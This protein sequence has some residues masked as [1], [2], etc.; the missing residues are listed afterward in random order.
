MKIVFFGTADFAVPSLQRMNESDHEVIGVVTAPDRRG[1]RGRKQ[2]ILS[3]VKNYALE[4][5]LYLLQPVN[6]KSEE[7]VRQLKSLQA[8]IFVVVAFRMLP[9]MVWSMPPMGTVNLHASLLPEYRGAAPIHHAIINGE[10]ETGLTV[11]KIA[12]E[13][14]TGDVLC[15]EVVKIEPHDTTGDLHDRMAIAGSKL[16]LN[17]IEKWAVG[18]IDLQTQDDR[19]ASPAPKLFKEF[20]ELDFNQPTALVYNKIRGLSPFPTAHTTIHGQMFK[21]FQARPEL[22]DEKLVKEPGTLITDEKSYLK[23]ATTDGAVNCLEVQLQGKKKMNIEEF[24]NGMG[25]QLPLKAG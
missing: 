19:L 24:L 16:L 22:F 6:L 5:E 1:G 21:I 20:C 13:I 18:K 17:C 15:R 8:D 3:P 14:D 25:N 9:R 4:N 2:R 10:T 12:E 7:F 23:I 11:F